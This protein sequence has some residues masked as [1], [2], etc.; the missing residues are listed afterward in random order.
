MENQGQIAKLLVKEV[1]SFKSAHAYKNHEQCIYHLGRAHILSQYKW[2]Q[3][4]YI[5]FLMFK[6]SWSRKD[7]TEI[8]AQVIR[9]A[10]TIPCHVIHKLPKGNTGWSNVGLTQ[11]LPLP[12]EFSNLF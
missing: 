6:Y 4:F 7:W 8:C 2:T 12:K 5:H 9:M 1:T 3:H 10:A 11:E